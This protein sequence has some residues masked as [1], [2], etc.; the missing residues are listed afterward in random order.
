MS[1]IYISALIYIY[2][3]YTYMYNIFIFLY[4]YLYILLY[5]HLLYFFIVRRYNFISFLFSS[6]FENM[7]FQ[8]NKNVQK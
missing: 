2:F 7:T 1:K 8:K 3:M 4:I 6:I 5:I